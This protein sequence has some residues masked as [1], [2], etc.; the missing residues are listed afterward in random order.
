MKILSVG[1]CDAGIEFWIGEK[2][3]GVHLDGIDLD[4]RMIASAKERATARGL[5]WTFQ[6]GAA[7][8]AP[9]LLPDDHGSYDAVV[10]YELIE[11]VIDP[12]KFLSSLEVMLKPGGRIYISTP[13]GTYG[14]GHNPHHLRVY[15]PVDLASTLR[16]H[17]Q[18]VNMFAGPD[19]T[20][21][22]SYTPGPRRGE[23]AIWCGPGWERWSPMDIAMKGLGGSETAAVRLAEELDALGYLVTVYGEVEDCAFRSV[24]YRH[25]ERFDGMEHRQAV[26]C[27]RNPSLFDRPIKARNRILW[28][29]DTD[30][31]DV[32]TQK[33]ADQIDAFVTLSKWHHDHFAGVYPFIGTGRLHQFRNGINLRLFDPQPWEGR[34]Q[35]VLYT[36]SPDRGLDQLLKLWPRVLEQVPDAELAF[37]YAPVYQKVADS[38]PRVGAFRD[39]ITALADQPGVVQLPA[40]P[41]PELAKLM[42][43]S[44]VWAHPSWFGNGNA[45]FHETSCIGAM[46]AQAAGCY[47]IA[48]DWGAL[49]E[50]VRAGQLVNSGGP[51]SE[52][53]RDAFVDRM[54]EGL[55]SPV[56]GQAAVKHAPNAVADLGWNG[57]AVDFSRLIE[58]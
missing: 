6:Q 56:A 8:D 36:S 29:H 57:V 51:D 11:H 34:A 3:E 17:G 53:W 24:I 25:W 45:P 52:R 15:R 50:T 44:R 20:L 48:S 33:R 22:A 30:C 47:V 27:S 55:T 41:Q 31:G 38:D 26:I 32:L 13:N 40:Q 37:C 5:D 49:R 54:V 7:E 35:R 23:V 9:A 10:A 46:E 39:S 12:D 58:A 14:D 19:S 16:G 18:L 4:V 1:C 43:H 42:C 2:L 28:V 21:S